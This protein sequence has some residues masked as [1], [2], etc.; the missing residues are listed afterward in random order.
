MEL[1]LAS[2]FADRMMLVIE[3]F[4]QYKG[5]LPTIHSVAVVFD[6]E[7]GHWNMLDSNQSL[8]VKLS[9]KEVMD[10]LKYAYNIKV[11]EWVV[12]HTSN[13]PNT[14]WRNKLSYNNLRTKL[15]LDTRI[16]K[17]D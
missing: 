5:L 9:S 17:D 15:G 1:L 2:Y 11:F 6:H 14:K 8:I 7:Q 12:V 3:A 10:S 16:K 13:D 4:N